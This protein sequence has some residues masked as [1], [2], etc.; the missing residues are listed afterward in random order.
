MGCSQRPPDHGIGNS[1]DRPWF[2]LAYV[3]PKARLAPS[4]LRCAAGFSTFAED[5]RGRD[6]IIFSDNSGAEHAVDKGMM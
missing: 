2:V 4:L 5:V 1:I 3:F 6:V